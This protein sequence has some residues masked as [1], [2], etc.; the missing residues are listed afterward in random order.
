MSGSH[1]MEDPKDTSYHVSTWSVKP[2]GAIVDHS[3]GS[4]ETKN[5]LNVDSVDSCPSDETTDSSKSGRTD[6]IS[7]RESVVYLD[8]FWSTVDSETHANGMVSK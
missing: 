6:N 8:P 4:L 2:H 7:S 3:S 5:Y 1:E